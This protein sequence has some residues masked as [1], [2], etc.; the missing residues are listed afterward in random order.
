ISSEWFYD[1]SGTYIKKIR[2]GVK[3]ISGGTSYLPLASNLTESNP[4]TG[5]PSNPSSTAS[6]IIVDVVETTSYDYSDIMNV[7]E[8]LSYTC[9]GVQAKGPGFIQRKIY[10]LDSLLR[11][12]SIVVYVNGDFSV[13][14]EQ[15]SAFL[16][17]QDTTKWLLWKW[18]N[19]LSRKML[20]LYMPPAQPGNLSKNLRNIMYTPVHTCS[21][22]CGKPADDRFP[23]SSSAPLQ[24]PSQHTL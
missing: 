9:S 6:P 4:V 20:N 17:R 18:Q 23:L 3:T 2:R 10:S 16:Q 13:K 14:T 8:D 5:C 11:I 7:K 19:L 22:K 15:D 21:H 12:K 1:A 24:Y